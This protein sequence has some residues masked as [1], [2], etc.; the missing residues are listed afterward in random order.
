MLTV[1]AAVIERDDQILIAQRLR[2]ARHE[3][4]WEFPGGKVEP[5]ESPPDALRRELTEELA[6]H[7]EIGPEITRYEYTYAGRTP[8]LLIFYR[9]TEFSGDPQNL[10]FEKIV[11]EKRNR[12]PHYDFLEGD[13][14]FVRSLAGA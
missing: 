5:G 2:G 9:V 11:W 4:K 6:I 14:G 10:T 13:I 1:V 7:A 8:F 3:L 12:L